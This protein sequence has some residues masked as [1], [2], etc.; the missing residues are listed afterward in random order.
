MNKKGLSVIFGV[1]ILI[2]IAVIAG[3]IIYLY[4]SG[5]LATMM[6]GGGAGQ[7]KVSIISISNTATTITAN[8][9]SVGGGA[10]EITDAVIKDAS[11]TTLATVTGIGT[12]LPAS[13]ATTQVPITYTCTIGDYYTVTL[14]TKLG[15]TFVSTSF[16]AS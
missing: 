2:A 6:G 1:L 13:G 16:K 9:K 14:V 7:E 12:T 3:I 10:V 11:G 8:A 4:T 15:N 5:Y